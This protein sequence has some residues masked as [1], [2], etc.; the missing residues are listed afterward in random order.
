MRLPKLGT[1]F[2]LSLALAAL[3]AGGSLADIT[4]KNND[5]QNP[6]S[7]TI[8]ITPGP[9]GTKKISLKRQIR[10]EKATTW[11]PFDE[12]ITAGISK[13][14]P[15]GDGDYK[16]SGSTG[17]ESIFSVEINSPED[18]KPQKGQGK[19]KFHV[20]YDSQSAEFEI[21]HNEQVRLEKEFGEALNPPK[22]K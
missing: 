13:E 15:N 20:G 2:G 3:V 22:A 21:D 18:R 8:T 1:V 11:G 17:G 19:P 12:A 4:V 14:T 16:W 5:K 6:E 10:K 9:K 7:I